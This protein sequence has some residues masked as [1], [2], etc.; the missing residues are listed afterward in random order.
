[1]RKAFVVAW[2][3]T[4]ACLLA[5]SPTLSQQRVTDDEAV[6]AVVETITQAALGRGLRHLA[7]QLGS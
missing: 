7:I 4:I 5:V 1:M 6:K 2:L 3:I